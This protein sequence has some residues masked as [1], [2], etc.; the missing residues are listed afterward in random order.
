MRVGWAKLSAPTNENSRGKYDKR[1]NLA[2]LFIYIR[3]SLFLFPLTELF[4]D[5]KIKL[6]DCPNLTS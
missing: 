4:K 3:L 1:L 5:H 2:F 6:G